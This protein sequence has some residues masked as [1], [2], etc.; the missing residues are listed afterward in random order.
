MEL[1][2]YGIRDSWKYYHWIMWIEDI[3]NL[4]ESEKTLNLRDSFLYVYE[5]QEESSVFLMH[6]M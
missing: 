2:V 5:I 4:S 3:P 6:V 1:Y